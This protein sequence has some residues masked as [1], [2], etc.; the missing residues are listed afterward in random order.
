MMSQPGFKIFLILVCLMSM[1]C[2]PTTSLS[3]HG[4]LENSGVDLNS[5]TIPRDINDEI[6]AGA[7]ASSG[8]DIVGTAYGQKSIYH[9]D[10]WTNYVI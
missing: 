3:G 5:E 10:E 2:S 4:D 1:A 6:N 9:P 7:S 8:L